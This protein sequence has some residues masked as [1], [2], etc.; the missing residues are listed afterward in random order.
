MRVAQ[1]YLHLER[2][3][4]LAVGNVA[5]ILAGDADNPEYSL[6]ALAPGGNVRR[7]PLPDPM[8]M[9]YPER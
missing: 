2:L 1:E 9:E 4:I 7:I 3:I 8:T 5:D 6:E